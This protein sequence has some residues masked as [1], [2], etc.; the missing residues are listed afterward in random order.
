MKTELP[1]P[2]IR[3]VETRLPMIHAH[4]SGIDIGDT[5]YCIA[6]PDGQGARS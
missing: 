5:F 3:E 2:R 1:K 6:I 4:A